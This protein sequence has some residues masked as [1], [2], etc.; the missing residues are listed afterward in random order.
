MNTT[1]RWRRVRAVA[2]G[3]LLGS[4]VMAACGSDDTASP[5]GPPATGPTS[6][7]TAPAPTTASPS[8]GSADGAESV[9]LD[10]AAPDLGRVVS[11]AEEYV[12]ADLLALGIE[13]VASTA[14]VD[15]VGFQGLES[16]DTSA[17]EVLP[18]TTLSL[19]YLASLRPNT[20]VTTQFWIDQV[21]AGVLE[22]IADVVV[23]PDGLSGAERIEVLG[24]LVGRPEHAA[25][26]AAEVGAA[27]AA[28]AEQVG[29]GCEVSLATISPGPTVAAFVDGPWELP[30]AFQAVGCEL[31]PG[32][33]VAPPDA[34]GRA[35]L[36]EEQL[37]LLDSPTLVLMQNDAVD[38]ES[39]A[40]DA[41]R[42]SAI[43]Q[44]LPAVAT[45]GVVVVDRLG[46]PGAQGLIRFY[47]EIARIVGA[48]DD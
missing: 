24:E 14:T 27:Q 41:I 31:I 17:I 20:I 3:L 46:Y 47:G 1:H 45:D 42:S 39:D 13:P 35:W 38:G 36:S 34:N 5:A 11:L 21:G 10:A 12:L 26:V 7:D 15:A 18:Q 19:E 23:I 48:A 2:V 9:V 40:L 6:A 25:Q 32:P 30:S 33:D 4:T 29:D 37:G 22:G 8:V 16:Y 44:T 43:W 28:A